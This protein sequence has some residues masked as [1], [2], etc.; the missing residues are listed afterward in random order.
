M[1][2]EELAK[3]YGATYTPAVSTSVS[4]LASK[5]GATYTPPVAEVTEPKKSLVGTLLS[6]LKEGFQGL[7]TLYGGS[8]Q[9]IASK[10][11]EDVQAGA[12]DIQSG[13]V[14]KGVTKAALRTAGDVAGAVYAPVG[15]LIAGTGIGKVF[16]A[17]QASAEG[18]P[19]AKG[20]VSD[21]GKL[22][23]RVTN[24]PAVQQFALNHP[25]AGEDFGR[26]LNL[27]FGK[28]EKGKIEPAT[29]IARTSEQ[30]SSIPQTLN[31]LRPTAETIA[32]ERQAKL[33]QGFE[34]QN[35]RLKSADKS[36]NKN[37]ITRLSDAGKE[38][39]ITPIDT[40]SKYKISPNIEK[41]SIQMGDY[42]TGTG[43]LGKIRE[44]V[45]ALDSEIDTKLV[46]SGQK[47][48]LETL[49]QE[50]I[51]RAKNNDDFKQSGT[52]SS[53][54][55][56]INNRFDDYKTSYGDQIDVAEINNIRKIANKDYSPE[57]QD[58]SRLMGDVARDVVYN[59]TPDKAI[60]AL[61]RQQGELLA[62][63]KYAETIN[64][65][66]VVG[67]RLG[68]MA[69]RTTGAIIGSTIPRLP[70]IGPVVGAIGGEFASR[71]LQQSQFKSLW[72]EAR[73]LIQ[74]SNSSQQIPSAKATPKIATINQNIK[75]SPSK[76]A[77]VASTEKSI[78]DKSVP[79]K[80][81]IIQR[82][83]DKYKEIPNKEGG[84]VKIGG[85]TFKEIP[86][87][88]KK[89][90][91]KVSDYLNLSKEV[92]PKIEYMIEKL[93]P[94]YNINQDWTVPKMLDV[95]EKLVENTKTR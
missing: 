78:I 92:D 85:K 40:F 68:T 2:P 67:G 7:K 57:T 80:K 27:L 25:N 62:A 95:I 16:E 35:V 90:L 30:I 59:V 22:I 12:Q 42:K 18:K 26:L 69:L 66:K 52:V 65:T 37:T 58:V 11:A 19:N 50:A 44:H 94:K 1:T 34:Q 61:L 54:V 91:I 23:D 55:T 10:L 48:D 89:E 56:K 82:A 13:N 93:F 24:I 84:F 4:D 72:T 21:V 15:A 29:A 86:E 32:S 77:P 64:G 33:T 83:V 41:G 8:S 28:A 9:G 87:A 43:E 60:R 14:V 3:K 76:T 5:Y 49:R 38:E 46:N 17:A 36:F 20:E 71:A 73:A 45:S 53:N 47:I 31:N 79:Q 51:T 74:R 39:V 88:T 6:P 63:R 70:V 81:S 75:T